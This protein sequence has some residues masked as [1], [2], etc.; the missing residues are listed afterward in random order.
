MIAASSSVVRSAP[1]IVVATFATRSSAS[2]ACNSSTAL[3]RLRRAVRARPVSISR[4][5][6]SSARRAVG[7]VSASASRPRH[8]L[9]VA[10]SA[11]TPSSSILA[12]TR[13]TAGFVAGGGCVASHSAS[14]RRGSVPRSA[15]AAS[16]V[17]VAGSSPCAM[18]RNPCESA[19]ASPRSSPAASSG[20]IGRPEARSVL[21][22]VEA[23]SRSRRPFDL[24]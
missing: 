15:A 7:A 3:C 2:V 4:P 10:S 9:K 11:Q 8:A 13:S 17:A 19:S 14:V 22:S 6:S 24:A 16:D 5:S 21:S 18:A 23:A 20:S 12:A 1:S